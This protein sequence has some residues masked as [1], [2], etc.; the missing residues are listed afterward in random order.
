MWG[1]GPDPF[2]G[3]GVSTTTNFSSGIFQQTSWKNSSSVTPCPITE[4]GLYLLPLGSESEEI[5][6][7]AGT[8]IHPLSSGDLLT[9]YAAA[10]PGWVPNG[11]YTVGWL[12]LSSNDP[13]VII[14]R[15]TEAILIPIYDHETLCNGSPDCKYQG[16]RKNVIFASSVMPTK[17][18]DEFR[19]Y[20]GAGD[21]NTGTAVVQVLVNHDI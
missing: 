6:L 12:I 3:L 20:F 1:E 11:N 19:L 13:S 15:S 8:H 18:K 21:G 9:F 5:K 16:E 17:K 4:D 14:Q 2:P 7:E 10:T